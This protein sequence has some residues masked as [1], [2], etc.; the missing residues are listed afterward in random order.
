MTTP[1]AQLAVFFLRPPMT[2]DIATLVTPTDS[3]STKAATLDLEQFRDAAVRAE[4]S[5]TALETATRKVA[6]ALAQLAIGS[7]ISAIIQ[8]ADEYSKIGS[9]SKSQA[10]PQIEAKKVDSSDAAGKGAA[11]DGKK[12]TEAKDPAV[13]KAEELLAIFQQIDAAT[14]QSAQGVE[15]AFGRMGKAFGGLTTALSGYLVQ[16]TEIDKTL[17]ETKAKNPADSTAVKQAETKAAKDSAQAQVKSYRDMVVA[18]KGFFG[19]NTKGYQVLQTAEKAFRAYEM[20][21]SLEAMAKKVMSIATVT[22]ATLTSEETKSAAVSAGVA[23]Q[24]AAD[25]AKG[26]SAAT[27]GVATQAQGDPYT[28]FVRMAAMAAFMA[29][30]GFSVSSGGSSPNVA[31]QRQESQGTGS[32]LGDASAKSQSISRAVELA[33]TNS[34]IE[35]THTAGMLASLKN[36]ESSIGGLG[37]L[38]VRGTDITSLARSVGSTS[39][40]GFFG[41]LA[42]SI[43]GGKTS[44]D[45]TGFVI[46]KNTVGG[47][48][49]G[50]LSSQSYIDTTKSGGWFSSDKH[51][52]TLKALGTDVDAQFSKVING[53]AKSVTTSAG[54]LG[55]GGKAFEDQLSSFVVDIGKISLK[56]MTGDKIQEAL[57]AVF[58]KLGDDMAKFGVAGLAD[59]QRVGEGYFETLTRLAADYANLDS[60][61]ESIG[62]TFGA[63]GVA[64]IAAREG[65]IELAGGIDNLATQTNSFASNFLSK[66][67]QLAP[68][69]K[70][71]TDQLAAMGLQSLDTREKFK[72]YVLQLA[73]SGALATT[74]GAEQYTALLALAD[75]FAK[76][77]AATEDL[78]K[79]EQEIADERTELQKKL[80]ALTKSE[81]TQ[82]AEQR[83]AVADV[84]KALYDQVQAAQAVVTAKDALSQAYQTESAAANT[85]IEKTKAWVSTLKGLNDSLSLSS[86]SILTPEQQYAEARRQFEQTLAAANAGDASAQGQLSAAEQ[87]FL[88]ASQVVNASD[89]NYAADYARV[90]AANEEAAKWA[91]QQVDVQQASLD[92]LQAQVQ[93]L[94]TINSSVLTVAQAIANLQAA[95][96]VANNL[97]VAFETPQVSAVATAALASYSV[98][99]DEVA[100]SVQ[101]TAALRRYTGRGSASADVS[102]QDALVAEIKALREEVASAR[103]ERVQH[104]EAIIQGNKQAADSAAKTITEGAKAA[105][106]S[107]VWQKQSRK[108]AVV[109]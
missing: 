25:T 20:A 22:T 6:E 13:A 56:D 48:A 18:A 107:A 43:F 42:S 31:K 62:T 67:E 38:L 78:T 109:T 89:A 59:F 30:L 108:E 75:A 97:G 24:L 77:H 55:I 74:A 27:V 46:A 76:T 52:T 93:G 11:A 69:Q 95:M 32:V 15:S 92:A 88:K 40:G 14:K 1:T 37:S 81:A 4:Q 35:L 28:A 41:S 80:E 19:E 58:S 105:A 73:D 47:I 16:Q 82:L 104:T 100:A 96:G 65:L 98:D 63:T 87:A 29:T 21:M 102:S 57:E 64:S 10:K 51:N 66:A 8:L 53:L 9:T 70:Y 26:A 79:T 71:V 84:N 103:T 33:A 83:D 99:E 12:P 17:A 44:V 86:Q 54:L 36:I 7:E 85:A 91:A 39:S 2:V 3:Q 50:S 61:M 106:A 45:D 72:D 34:S 90:I 94:T 49:S 68:V 101:T 5:T 23:E 60:I